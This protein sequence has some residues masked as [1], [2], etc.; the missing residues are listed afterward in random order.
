MTAKLALETA[1]MDQELK[2]RCSEWC[3]CVCGRPSGIHRLWPVISR[4]SSYA[5]SWS[6]LG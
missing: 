5:D 3:V 1:K 6:V 2:V 4:L